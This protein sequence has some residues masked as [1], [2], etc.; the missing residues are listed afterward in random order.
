MDLVITALGD[1]GP[2][3]PM[4]SDQKK[5]KGFGLLWSKMLIVLR[6]DE[7]CSEDVRYAVMYGRYLNICSCSV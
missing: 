3:C 6:A 2:A 4:D 1:H 7:D 5:T